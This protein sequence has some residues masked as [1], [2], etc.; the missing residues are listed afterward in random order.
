VACFVSTAR[1]EP[2]PFLGWA[3]VFLLVS[4]QQDVSRLRIPN[5]LTF[6]ALAA[7]LVLAALQG[8]SA[9][10][11]GALAGAGAALGCTFLPFLLRWLGAGDVK[12]CMV[13]GAL[14][15]AQNF[16][17]VLPWMFVVGG[18]LA[19]VLLV[20]RGGLLEM[21]RRWFDSLRLTIVSGRVTYLP[22]AAGSAARAGIPF[23]LAMGLGACAYQMWGAS[24]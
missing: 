22:P 17:G 16:I 3:A 21:L 10:L 5:W 2:L 6:P 18:A 9:G 12:A 11:T 15:G 8:G 14:W 13:L 20:A 7:A 23:A 4:I 1:D 24:S 19:I